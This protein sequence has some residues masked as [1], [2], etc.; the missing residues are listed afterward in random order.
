VFR[1]CSPKVTEDFTPNGSPNGIAGY[2]QKG[3]V[4]GMMHTRTGD[5][6]PARS[7]EVLP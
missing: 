2:Q 5:G 3:N 6:E 7:L 1:Y 4:L